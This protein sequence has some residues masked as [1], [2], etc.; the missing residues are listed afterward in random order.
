MS[1][2]IPTV[3]NVPTVLNGR[4][5]RVLGDLPD[6]S[7]DAV[8]ADPPYAL[9]DLP[10]AKIAEALTRW[11]AGERD[12]VPNTGA[13]FMGKRWDK[14]VPP[15][16]LW[17][18]VLR[19]LKPGGHAAVFAG[20]RTQDLMGMSLRLAGFEI[21]DGLQWLYG[22]GMPKT[23]SQLKPAYEPILLVRKPFVGTL[24]ANHEQW[25]VGGLFVER[26]RVPFISADDERESKGKNRHGD[27]GTAN[28]GNTVYGDYSMLAGRTNYN[29]PGRWP[30]NVLLSHHPDCV[31]GG[32]V[33]V[34]SNGH[35]PARRGPGGIA[36]SGHSGQVGLVERSA[37]TETVQSWRCA[38]G[39]PVRQ[40]DKQSG[41]P[42]GVGG[43][44]RFLYTAK[45]PAAERP[46]YVSDDGVRV[47]HMTVKP[48]AIVRWL[49]K[50]LTPDGGTV[51]DPFAGS[52]TTGEACMLEGFR[53]I[54]IEDDPGYLPLI[55]QRI[56]RQLTTPP[57][58]RA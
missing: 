13:G 18:E 41:G 37:R 2:L 44:S 24:K 54:L 38:D 11:L 43:A 48:L 45:A 32:T 7:V 31:P 52:G 51:L 16:A 27:F 8:I 1:G 55:Q 23:K 17:E 57:S 3:L 22:Q 14:F 25:G 21:R 19:V 35:H 50:L 5:E 33:E 36:S 53:S 39:C 6:N 30:A 12:W 58:P 29:P 28:G 40:L 47:E 42:D 34:R 56:E 49:A 46:S 9:T 26:C 15:P 10:S 4:S 20:S